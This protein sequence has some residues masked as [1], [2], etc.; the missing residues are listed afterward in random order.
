MASK[1]SKKFLAEEIEKAKVTIEQ[2]KIGILVNELIL[3]AFQE[4]LKK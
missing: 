4:E 1:L 2:L 3:K